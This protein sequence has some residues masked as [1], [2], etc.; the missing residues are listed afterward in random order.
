M[1]KYLTGKSEMSELEAENK[2]LCEKWHLHS[3]YSDLEKLKQNMISVKVFIES[4][5]NL[6]Y[7]FTQGEFEYIITK[8]DMLTSN[9]VKKDIRNGIPIKYTRELILKMFNVDYVDIHNLKENFKTRFLSIFKNRDPKNIGDHVPYLSYL[10]TFEENLPN[11]F[12]N[13]KGV[14]AIKELLWLLYSVVPNIEFCPLLIK[15]I[16]LSLIFLSKEETFAFMKNLM[17]QDYSNKNL[18]KIRFRLRFNYEEN[19][20]LIPAFLESFKNI[21]KTTGKEIFKKLSNLKFEVE[22]LIEDMFF[23]LFIGYLNFTFLHRVFI[24]YLNEGCKILFRVAYAILK[25]LKNDILDI[26]K[27]E[28]VISTIKSKTFELKDEHSFFSHIYYFK[29]TER[30]NM[31]EEMKIVET[32]KPNKIENYYIPTLNGESNIMSD[33]EIFGLWN[34]FPDNF[35]L[36]DAKLIFSTDYQG[37]SLDRIYETC[38]DPENSCFNCFLILSTNKGDVFGVIMSLP[39]DKNR[40]GFYKLA[41]TALFVLRPYTM[42]YEIVQ[43]SDRMILCVEDKIL[44]GLGKE[45]PALEIEKDLL[46]GFSYKSEIFG[47]PCLAASSI[48]KKD[49]SFEISKLEVYILY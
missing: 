17:I 45:G 8:P 5:E 14:D 34:I 11:H 24:L 32:F 38:L 27:L 13:E 2:L 19:K 44:I 28:H 48:N 36:K 39:L 31:Y 41:Y 7:Y 23:N 35:K 21:T 20:K 6:E 37:K 15:I 47:S 29:L 30:N 9:R 22:I 26:N 43:S 12:L 18:Y 3:G 1:L 46:I 40:T 49:N 10:Y 33:D 16:S 42:I 25:T 4:Q